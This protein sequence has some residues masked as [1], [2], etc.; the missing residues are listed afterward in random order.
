MLYYYPSEIPNH[1]DKTKLNHI[2]NKTYSTTMLYS[3]EGMF[4]IQKGKLYSVHFNDDITSKKIKIDNKEYITDETEIQ[5]KPC[6]KLP[7][8]FLRKDITVN[9]YE[10]GSI[11]MYLEEF[12]N[13]VIHMY[14]FVKDR[15]IHGIHEDIQELMRKVLKASF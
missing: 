12:N 4:Q 3:N 11:K 7:Y 10:K 5:W 14:F 9:C 15:N 2:S 13:C 8:D 1:V 6:N